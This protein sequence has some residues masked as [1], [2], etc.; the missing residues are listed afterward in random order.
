M[1]G[2]KEGLGVKRGS[3]V[4]DDNRIRIFMINTPVLSLIESAFHKEMDLPRNQILYEG[5]RAN[6]LKASPGGDHTN[7]LLC[8]ELIIP[9]GSKKYLAQYIREDI[10][11]FFQ[12]TVKRKKIDAECLILTLKNSGNIT[13]N[14]SGSLDV[15]LDKKKLE[16]Y[17]HNA[18]ASSVA[19]YISPLFDL[20]VIDETNSS[21][22]VNISF[23]NLN[24]QSAII[25]SLEKAGFKVTQGKRELDFAVITDYPAGQ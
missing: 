16:N 2:Y 23:D 22:I 13:N 14:F 19:A 6:A 1:S 3:S 7:S 12:L 9:S 24:D 5:Q 11:R 21:Q 8:Y 17:I 10:Q 18:P 25:K 4:I 15:R 20:P